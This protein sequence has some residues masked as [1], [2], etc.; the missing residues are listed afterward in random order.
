MISLVEGHEP[1]HK[2]SHFVHGQ[3]FA[4]DGSVHG[5]IGAAYWALMPSCSVDATPDRYRHVAIR[6]W[7]HAITQDIVLELIVPALLLALP[8][9][10]GCALDVKDQR[11]AG[12]VDGD[13][14]EMRARTH[15]CGF[16]LG[17]ASLGLVAF[18]ELRAFGLE[19]LQRITPLAVDQQQPAWLGAEVAC[20]GAIRVL[21]IGGDQ[22]PG[23]GKRWGICHV[24]GKCR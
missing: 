3:A 9:G 24:V 5:M 4:D 22:G 6:A 2:Q 17:I 13:R 1:H 7:R 23:P 16:V 18:G 19:D 20:D 12:R 10:K 8:I 14:A 11:A 21:Y 15:D